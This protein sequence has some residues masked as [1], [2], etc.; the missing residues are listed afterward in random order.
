MEFDSSQWSPV[1]ERQWA[2]I[3]VQEIPLKYKGD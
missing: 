1:T 2:Q 3:K